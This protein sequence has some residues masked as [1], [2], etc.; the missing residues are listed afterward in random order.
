[1]AHPIQKQPLHNFRQMNNL[2]GNAR[3]NKH[4]NKYMAHDDK[5]DLV[6]FSERWVWYRR[7]AYEFEKLK[8]VQNCNTFTNFEIF[9]ILYL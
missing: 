2:Q 1:M 4:T 3:T 7:R 6:C 5:M 8:F 9:K